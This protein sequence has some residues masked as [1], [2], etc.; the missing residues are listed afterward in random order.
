MLL[1]PTGKL[2]FKG[3]S[4]CQF[5]LELDYSIKSHSNGSKLNTIFAINKYYVLSKEI[6]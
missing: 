2:T 4:D 6:K 3:I 5:D 1:C